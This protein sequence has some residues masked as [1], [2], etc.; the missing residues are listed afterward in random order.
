MKAISFDAPQQISLI[1][2]PLPES[3]GPGEVKVAV[4]RVGICGTDV[5]CYLGKFPFFSFP[6]TPGHELGV[7]VLECGEGVENIQVGDRCSV[8]PYLNNPDS[9]S[10]Q[11][12]RPNCCDDLRVIGV[13]MNGGMCEQFNLP[14][15]KLHKSDTLSFDQLALVET[16]AIGYHAV[17]RGNVQKGE[18]VLIIGSGPIGLAALEF[19]RVRGGRPIVLDLNA[20]RLAFCHEQMNVAD[21]VLVE[22]DGSEIEKIKDMTEGNLCQVVIDATGNNLS[23]SNALE[24]VAFG[25]RLV[26]VGITSGKISFLHPLMHRRE[27][28]L[29]ASRNAHAADFD[30]IIKLMEN[31]AV[32]TDPWITHRTTMENLADDFPRFLDPKSGV[33]KAMIGIT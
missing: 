24:Y 23:M 6:R 26:Y 19:V 22:I 33:L 1:D 15:H 28:T 18:N 17:E 32:N 10:S 8:E 20:D 5:S 3:P 31:G 14:G 30:E 4:H 13:H 16:L 27:M 7:E 12:G 11:I 21:T 25:G 29:I 2:S 9:Y